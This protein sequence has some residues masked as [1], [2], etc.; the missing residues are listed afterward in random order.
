MPCVS[1][2]EMRFDSVFEMVSVKQYVLA[3]EIRSVM[4]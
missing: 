4:A 2:F 3:F 1:E